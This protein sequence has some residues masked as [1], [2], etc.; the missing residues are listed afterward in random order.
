MNKT[1][2]DLSNRRSTRAFKSEQITEEELCVILEAGRSAPSSMNRQPWHFT[3]IQ[4]KDILD[5]MVKT[6]KEIVLSSAELTKANP[7]INAADYNNFYHAPTVILISGD[8]AN[9]WHV[10]DCALAMENMTLAAHAV[11]IGS[12]IVAS[13][14]FL[15]QT[16][17]AQ[18]YFNKFNIPE[19]YIPLY[20][21]ALGYIDGENPKPT[22]RKEDCV[23][24][25][26]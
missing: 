8:S 13:T 12:C 15:F 24:F 2:Q 11:S 23:N 19:G 6:N 16:S 4:N 9:I 26:R 25:I 1:L 22:P 14:R 10:C 7:W 5:W 20:A 18:E 17:S 3:V 21:L